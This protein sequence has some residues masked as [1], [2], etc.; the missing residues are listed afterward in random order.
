MAEDAQSI[1]IAPLAMGLLQDLESAMKLE[2]DRPEASG[3]AR[4]EDL[5]GR[6][7]KDRDEGLAGPKSRY[8]ERTEDVQ[9][10]LTQRRTRL[11]AY[12]LRQRQAVQPDPDS[13]IFA[14]RIV[15]QAT[16]DGLPNVDIRMTGA[17]V[18]GK[19]VAHTDALGYFRVER[20]AADL[21]SLGDDQRATTLEILGEDGEPMF[22]SPAVR[23]DAGKAEFLAAEIDAARVA[24]S[25]KL[26]DR[27]GTA[28]D[29]RIKDLDRRVRVLTPR[30]DARLQPSTPVLSPRPPQPVRPEPD[31]PARPPADPERRRI[32]VMDIHAI[33]PEERKRLH[34]AGID[35]AAT[36]AK[37]R[38]QKLAELLD[39]SAHRA[40]VIVKEA[41]KLVDDRN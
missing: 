2:Q 3:L 21:E 7:R 22:T 25:R 13:F 15:D 4:L 9:S 5:A 17:G 39:V 36:L 40:K 1:R 38:P 8:R 23:A 12:A 24:E 20:G 35:D 26:A 37:V 27:I 14:G 31:D 19:V 29:D 30:V 28:I 33:K 16:G 34:A 11:E 6:I 41:G 32:P 10:L 18:D